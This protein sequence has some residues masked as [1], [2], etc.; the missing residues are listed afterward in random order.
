MMEEKVDDEGKKEVVRF[1]NDNLPSDQQVSLDKADALLK[2]IFSMG[3]TLANIKRKDVEK[4]IKYARELLEVVKRDFNTS[5]N[6]YQSKDYGNSIGLM[7]QVVEKLVKAYCAAFHILTIEE[8]RKVGHK[9]PMAFVKMVHV[10]W[11]KPTVQVLEERHPE[12]K[13]DTRP[14]EDAIHNKQKELAL[15]DEKSIETYLILCKNIN[16]ALKEKEE[17]IRTGISSIVANTSE[18]LTEE[19]SKKFKFLEEKFNIGWASALVQLYLFYY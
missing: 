12:L 13:T 7:Q 5:K 15:V 11:V 14:L 18:L 17:I 8:I 19:D 10:D 16:K 6:N 1:V 3:E 4:N 9:T 2:M